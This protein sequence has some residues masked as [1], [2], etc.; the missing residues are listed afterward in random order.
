MK[1]STFG[2]KVWRLF[3]AL[4][5]IGGLAWTYSLLP[6][7]VAVDFAASGTAANYVEKGTI[8]YI[9]M[10]LIIVNNVVFMGM[11]RQIAKIPTSLL[12]IPN[13]A[14]WVDHREELNGHLT[15]WLYSL[16]AAINTIVALSLF[17]LATV[18]S[19][20]YKSN[21]FDYAWL[22]YLGFGMLIL[23]FAALPVRLMRAPAPEITLD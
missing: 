1:V 3:S 6:D 5:V 21:I 15:N 10:G 9:A 12:P 2:I 11:A 22:F 4:L 7:L 16:V 17:A 20:Q 23:I 13:R 18:N 19:N 14:A 8:F